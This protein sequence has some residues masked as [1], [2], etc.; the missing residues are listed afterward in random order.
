MSIYDITIASVGG[1]SPSDGFIDSKNV[2]QYMAD[3]SPTTPTNFALATAKSRANRRHKAVVNMIDFYSNFEM[4]AVI[5]GGS[6]TASTN[7]TNMV[8]RVMGDLAN[9]STRDELNQGQTL[10]GE[11][12]VKRI[13]ARALA[14]TEKVGLEVFDP[15]MSTAPG[16]ATS[17]NRTGPRFIE[18]TVGP[19][20]G[21]LAAAEASVTVTLVP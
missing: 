9:I 15:T 21:S 17:Y 4:V 8:Y 19:L 3:A 14:K 10:V 2:Y 13:V 6:P 20:Y 11:A 5:Q 7:P 18:E 12:A 16:N 1:A